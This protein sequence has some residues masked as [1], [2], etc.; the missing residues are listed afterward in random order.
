[1]VVA[2][3]RRHFHFRIFENFAFVV[4]DHDLFVVMV[5]DVSRVNRNFTAAPGR[6]DH[7]LWH[8]VTGS[9]TPQTLDNLDPLCYRG[10]Q[11]SRT[12][13]QVTLID[14]VGTD[15][16]DHKLVNQCSHHGQIVV[17]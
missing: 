12:E 8:S 16:A 3:L 17:Y 9:V 5:E 11:V 6:V 14:V 13:N 10:S 15:A 1:G 2:A 7:E 4:S